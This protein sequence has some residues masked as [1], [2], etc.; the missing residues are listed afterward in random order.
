LENIEKAE[1][2]G[3]GGVARAIAYGLKQEKIEVHVSARSQKQRKE[4]VEELNLSGHSTLEEQGKNNTELVVNATPIADQPESPVEIDKHEKG[5]W[6]LEVVFEDLETDII[7][8]AD[9]EGWKTTRGWRMLLHQGLEQ[10]ELYTGEKGPE[11][12]MG[13]VL[14]NAL[15]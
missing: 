4:L 9:E 7:R 15:S 5:E 11:E 3:A 13:K 6:L 14:E 12:A 1:I 10:F 8:E 2:I